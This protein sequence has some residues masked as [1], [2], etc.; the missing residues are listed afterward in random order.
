MAAQ[1]EGGGMDEHTREFVGDGRGPPDPRWPEGAR[2]AL[3]FVV[4]YEEGSEQS[5]PD[6]DGA[7]EQ[8]LTEGGGGAFAG[9]DLGAESMFEYGSRVGVWRLFRLF[10][11]R[12]L[13]ATVFAC[14]QALERNPE[15]GATM[16][17]HGF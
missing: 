17:E 12:R 1:R 2:L 14:A 10:A 3:N 8:G 11:E 4:N 15:V 13:P 9:R 7:T 16:R 6:G 5:I